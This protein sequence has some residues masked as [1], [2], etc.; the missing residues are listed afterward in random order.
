MGALCAYYP[1]LVPVKMECLAHSLANLQREGALKGSK[2]KHSDLHGHANVP[3]GETQKSQQD[4]GEDLG[5]PISSRDSR[6]REDGCRRE[7]I[8]DNRTAYCSFTCVPCTKKG[9]L[10]QKRC[11]W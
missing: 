10:V 7:L 4:F 5:T 3:G 6:I 9:V 1:K 11:S 8:W 2:E